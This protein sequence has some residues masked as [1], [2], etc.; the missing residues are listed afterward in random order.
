MGHSFDGYEFPCLLIINV[1]Y[2]EKSSYFQIASFAQYAIIPKAVQTLFFLLLIH[3]RILTRREVGDNCFPFYHK[4][5][6]PKKKKKFYLK[7]R[8]KCIFHLELVE[9]YLSVFPW[10]LYPQ[11]LLPGSSCFHKCKA[12]AVAAV[13]YTCLPLSGL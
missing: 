12:V 13:H 1:F 7:C 3:C 5:S 9:F 8:P 10:H 4:M 11:N 2:K 6:L